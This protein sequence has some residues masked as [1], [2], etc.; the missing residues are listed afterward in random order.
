MKNKHDLV[1]VTILTGFL[2]AGKTTLLNH[3]LTA[4][5]GQKIAVIV[6]E[7]GEVGIDNQLVVGAD[8]EIFE[9]NNGCI[10]CTVRGDL[11]RILGELM[12]AK[13]GLGRQQ[14]NFDR[15]IIETTGLADPAPVAQTFFVDPHI[16]A[17][18]TI[19]SIVTLVDARHAEQHLDEGHEAQ[20]QVAFADVLLLNKIDLVEEMELEKLEKRLKAMNPTAKI[21]R[22]ENS[23]IELDKI[24]GIHS[25]DLDKKIEL[26]PHFLEEEDEHHHH[27]HD[28]TVKSFVLRE[29][30][31]LDLVKL[32]RLMNLLVRDFGENLFRYKGILSIQGVDRR[33]VFQGIHMLF[34]STADRLWKPGEKRVS[35]IVFIG[36]NLDKKMFEDAFAQCVV[37]IAQAN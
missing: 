10:C 1:P 9:M 16:E 25:F 2:G 8:E 20:E 31:P 6:N 13:Q 17:F 36:R 11:I 5:H 28:D 30:R 15:V 34:A 18:Y 23:I 7:F 4:N 29:D 21:F 27:H 37:K 19:D 33:I 26:D 14:V 3:I 24:L 22:T 32:E 35:E 12:R